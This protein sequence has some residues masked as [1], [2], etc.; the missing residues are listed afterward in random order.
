VNILRFT[1]DGAAL[2]SG[3]DDSGVGVWSISRYV[4]IMPD[5]LDVS[6]LDF[7]RLLDEDI[8]ADLVTPFCTLSDHTLP[9]TD[10]VCGVGPFPT[11]RILTSSV[12]HSVKV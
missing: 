9:V 11:C 12:D 2:V 8:E 6:L 10:I 5:A 4:D 3:S 1:R 7:R